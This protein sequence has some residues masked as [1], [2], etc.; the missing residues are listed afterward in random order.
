MGKHPGATEAEN[1]SWV[2]RNKLTMPISPTQQPS[3]EVLFEAPND[4]SIKYYLPRYKVAEQGERYRVKLEKTTGN[5]AAAWQLTVYLT[6]YPASAIANQNTN[7]SEIDHMPEVSL[8]YKALYKEAGRIEM[9]EVFQELLVQPDGSLQAVLKISNLEDRDRI[10]QAF[11]TSACQAQ[12]RIKRK[13]L[14]AFPV[15]FKRSYTPEATPYRIAHETFESAVGFYFSTDIHSYIYQG[16]TVGAAQQNTVAHRV[17]SHIYL[18][19]GDSKRFFYLP[20][21]FK[22]ARTSSFPRALVRYKLYWRE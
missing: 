12:L 1:P 16:I 18:Q 21:E 19:E 8:H 3:D 15:N 11:T 9:Q 20:D 14:I 10:H 17:E 13:A 7:A 22:L 4:K 2:P 6:K 5:Q